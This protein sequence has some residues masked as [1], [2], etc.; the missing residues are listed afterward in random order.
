MENLVPEFYFPQ[1]IEL[2]S[3]PLLEAWL[4]IRWQLESG[5]VTNL[6][7]DPDF[8]FALGAFF[9]SVRDEFPHKKDLGVSNVVPLEM[10]PYVVRHQ[11]W[12]SQD[13]WPL[14]QLGPGVATVN[15]SR[16]Y[17]WDLFQERALYLREKLLDAY[18]DKELETQ[19]LALRYRNGVPFDYASNDL[20]EF[21][22]RNLNTSLTLP[23]HIP[24]P[25]SNTAW[26]S[27]AM[28]RL[29][30][31]LATPPGT[32]VLQ[33]GTANRQRPDPRARQ[34]V[35][36]RLLLWQLE[37]ESVA[38][39]VADL[40]LEDDFSHWLASAHAV[41]HEW[42]FSLISGPLYNEYKEG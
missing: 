35:T 15:F 31:D 30:F 17:T 28:I 42:F 5:P 10:A 37:V 7:R 16:P 38:P 20:L 2:K 19:S 25:T 40:N 32:G 3:N 12:A 21:F 14:L 26:P 23:E 24:G 41:T 33:L 9:S 22:S 11:F 29:T 8:P 36:E 34:P 13:K 39:Q 18:G 1:D 4:E 6:Q 27:T